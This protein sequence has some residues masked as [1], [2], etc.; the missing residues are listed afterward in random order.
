MKIGLQLQKTLPE[1][2]DYEAPK[3]IKRQNLEKRVVI[4]HKGVKLT[5][6]SS[7]TSTTN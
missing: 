6:Q 7:Y 4:Q 1:R 2:F 3:G 5:R